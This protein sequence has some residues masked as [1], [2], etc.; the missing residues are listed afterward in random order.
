M[1]EIKE[2]NG[3]KSRE[4]PEK[5][6]PVSNGSSISNGISNGAGNGFA[7]KDLKDKTSDVSDKNGKLLPKQD[8][9]VVTTIRLKPQI[10]LFQAVCIIVGI[11][12]GSGIFVSPVGILL[13][14]KS[15][16][17]GGEYTYI[18][19][20]FGD[21]PGFIA[22]WINFVVIC[23]VCVAASCLIFATYILRPLYPDCEPP[24]T[25]IRLLAALIIC[26]LIIVNCV[27]VKWATKVQIVI[28]ASKLIALFMIIIIGFVYIGKG[29]VENFY[30]SFEGSDYSAGAIAISFYSGFWAF[31][32][33][34][35]LNFLTDELLEPHKNLPR[36]II[37]SMTIVTTVYIVANI[38]YFSVLSPIEVIKS[39]AVAVT[40]TE[41]TVGKITWLIPILI[42]ISVMGSMNGT[43]LS[44][45]RLFFVGARN[46]H[47]PSIISMINCRFL[48]P[49]PSLLIILVLTIIM[50]G[51]ENIFYL[52]E[53]MGFSFCTVLTCVFAGQ[54]YLRYKEP[55][56]KRPIKLPIL[57]PIFLFLISIVL[58]AMTIVQRPNESLTTLLI[59]ALGIPFYIIGVGWK[60]KPKSFERLNYKV[61]V[62][63]QK[64]L[65][66]VPQDKDTTW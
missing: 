20:A 14:V 29:H 56:L 52:I 38:A 39:S 34:S 60:S 7:M 40:F 59:M 30:N 5:T 44:M 23:P 11:I 18:R 2:Q 66:V 24:S 36:A 27:N 64:I 31:G 1:E 8:E 41:H 37:I 26:L 16:E 43:S 28:T 35:Y 48:T 15:V 6:S 51:F 32:G 55:D 12:I 19:R 63:I 46:N 47:L 65:M 9:L 54:V 53:M 13:N 61:T 33:W 3:M 42:A 45:S 22:M 17:S 49:A 21:F 25:S 62:L 57:L 50:Q 58:L 4:T 10:G